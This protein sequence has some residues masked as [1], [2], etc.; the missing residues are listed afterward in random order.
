LIAEEAV[1][2]SILQHQFISFAKGMPAIA[3]SNDQ[4]DRELMQLET[5]LRGQ[6]PDQPAIVTGNIPMPVYG[7]AF[8][9]FLESLKVTLYPGYAELEATII[10]TVHRQGRPAGIIREYRVETED[11]IKIVF[12]Y[13]ATEREV[14]WR[15]DGISFPKI[16]RTWGPD[17]DTVLALTT[18]PE[19]KRDTYLSE[20]ETQI[21]WSTRNTFVALLIDV[22]PRYPL[23]EMCPWLSFIEPLR[24]DYGV[25]HIVVTASKAQ[26]SVG[27][28][29][30]STIIVEPDPEFPYGEAIPSPSFSAREVDIAVY[31]PKT[32]LIDFVSGSIEPAILVANKGRQGSIKWSVSGA[33]GLK[34]LT[35]DIKSGLAFGRPNRP[36]VSGV[37][38]VFTAI[39]FVGAAR[40][41]VDGPSG[42]R[43]GL[44]GGSVLGS[45]EFSADIRIEANLSVG[46]ITGD[47]KVTRS[48]LIDID[49]DTST[50]FGWPLDAISGEILDHVAK[51]EI[52]KLTNRVV[53]LGRWDFMGIPLSYL[54]SLGVYRG[55]AVM[56]G[57]K[58]VSAY[59][60]IAQRADLLSEQVS[61]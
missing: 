36:G 34:Q 45:G 37:I 56:E 47:L 26:I 16:T 44:A 53:H 17:A 57:L 3:F 49:F 55:L 1:S 48:E 9:T 28:C 11:P 41:W 15:Q 59:M 60:G 40:A 61:D 2:I 54:D 46:F 22:L 14:Y 32:R 52:R 38:G 42:T 27:G 18:I 19:P 51:K 25:E 30:Q 20:V 4:I 29:T 35:A 6:Y 58:G 31:I 8:S 39:D 33:F 43:I 24:F 5:K 7:L 13:E 12:D 21:I 50:P 23:G 10:A